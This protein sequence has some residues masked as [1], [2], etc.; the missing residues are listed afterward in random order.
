MSECV[1]YIHR[2]VTFNDQSLLDGKSK[3]LINKGLYNQ[4]FGEAF[5][6]KYTVRIARPEKGSVAPYKYNASFAFCSPADT[7]PK[8]ISA[9]KKVNGKKIIGFSKELARKSLMVVLHVIVR[10][11]G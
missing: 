1:I 7:T 10:I 11:R 9:S 4:R 3:S 6:A 8:L 2:T 5:G